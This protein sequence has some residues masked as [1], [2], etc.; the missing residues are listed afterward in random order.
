MKIAIVGK[1]NKGSWLVRGPQ[2]VLA[3]RSLGHQADCYDVRQVPIPKNYDRIVYVKRGVPK[4]W[5]DHVPVYWDMVDFWKQP[6]EENFTR[7]QA[8][9]LAHSYCPP[10]VQKITATR[11]M[12]ADVGGTVLYHHFRPGIIAHPPRDKARRPIVLYE[13]NPRYLGGYQRVLEKYCDLVLQPAPWR[14]DAVLAIR[15][16]PFNGYMS[17]NWK[18]N[19][20][21]ANALAMGRVLITDAEV[22]VTETTPAECRIHVSKPTDIS[23]AI[24]QITINRVRF[25]AYKAAKN[26]ASRF[27]LTHIAKQY[28]E[29]LR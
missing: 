14:C 26:A 27:E 2:L 19:V 22:G 4:E 13:G 24:Q 1:P 12:G 15:D 16:T 18:S 8:I 28:L 11:R 10:H 20:K 9:A 7:D 25:D 21:A 3:L 6:A 5:P 29:I 17:R 23:W